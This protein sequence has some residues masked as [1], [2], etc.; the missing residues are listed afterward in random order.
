MSLELI[1]QEIKA[2][3]NLL[4]SGLSLEEASEEQLEREARR[5]RVKIGEEEF[6]SRQAG[7]FVSEN[8]LLFDEA[9]S[10]VYAGDSHLLLIE[11]F[12]Q[13]RYLD[14]SDLD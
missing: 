12:K 4:P 7:T 9:F 11:V 6:I 5:Y 10:Y 13:H 14:N 1:I 3:G 8:Q 2:I